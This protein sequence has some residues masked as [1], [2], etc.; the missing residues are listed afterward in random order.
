MNSPPTTI[1]NTNQPTNKQMKPSN[2]KYVQ[3]QIPNYTHFH[4]F[5]TVCFHVGCFESDTRHEFYS[6]Y[7][8]FFILYR[9]SLT[10]AITIIH[11]FCFCFVCGIFVCIFVSCIHFTSSTYSQTYAHITFV[12]I[13]FYSLVVCSIYTLLISIYSPIF[14]M[15]NLCNGQRNVNTNAIYLFKQTKRKTNNFGSTTKNHPRLLI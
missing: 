14:T 2:K 5:H 10:T 6:I 7:S 9:S 3:Q 11:K 12:S 13:R 4:H 8:V 1:T 15:P